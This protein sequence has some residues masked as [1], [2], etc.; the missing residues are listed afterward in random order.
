[1]P[2]QGVSNGVA[3]CDLHF[4]KVKSGC[5][6]GGELQEGWAETASETNSIAVIQAQGTELAVGGW[7]EFLKKWPSDL[8]CT[9]WMG[10]WKRKP[11]TG[12]FQISGLSNEENGTV[13]CDQGKGTRTVSRAHHM[14][15]IRLGLYLNIRNTSHVK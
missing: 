11:M 12:L 4:E 1:M 10:G 5:S 2:L 9:V 13:S 3:G 7:E 8:L 6:V 15:K 14:P